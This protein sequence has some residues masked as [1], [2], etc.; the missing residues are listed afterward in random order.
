MS[1]IQ[2]DPK[3]DF[4]YQNLPYGIFSTNTSPRK[5]IGVAI[6]DYVLDLSQVKHLFNGPAMAQHQHVLDASTLNELM[7][8]GRSAW[9]E[10]RAKLLEILSA[11]SPV[12]RDDTDLK[13]KALIEQTKCIMHLPADIG[14]YTDFYSSR[15]HAT[16]VG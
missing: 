14:D 13:S 4:S 5:R 8:L 12:L 10:T 1:F 3:S 9:Q 6:G 7:S 11:D 16:N 2:I 15:Q